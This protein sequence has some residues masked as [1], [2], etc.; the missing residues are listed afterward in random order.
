MVCPAHIQ[1]MFSSGNR[2]PWTQ[3]EL[4]E[5]FAKISQLDRTSCTRY[6]AASTRFCLFIDGLDEYAGHEAD[7]IKLCNLT[8][9]STHIKLCVASRSWP[10]FRDAF[11]GDGSQ[12]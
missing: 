6:I 8:V 4:W 9:R 11:A 5:G 12:I 1:H 2:D 3:A 10:A 7:V